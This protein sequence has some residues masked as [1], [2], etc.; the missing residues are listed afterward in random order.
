[1][2][3]VTCPARKGALSRG[4]PLALMSYPVRGAR[5]QLALCVRANTCQDCGQQRAMSASY[6]HRYLQLVLGGRF[7]FFI[8]L[9]AMRALRRRFHVVS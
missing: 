4:A 9:L 8:S 2:L 3:P 7:S 1:M 5:P 6:L